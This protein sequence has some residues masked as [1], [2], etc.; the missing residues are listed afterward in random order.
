MASIVKIKRSNVAGNTPTTSNIVEGELALNT[1]DHKLYSRGGGTVFEVG[2]NVSSFS[3]DGVEVVDPSRNIYGNEY[4]IGTSDNHGR[5]QVTNSTT[6]HYGFDP[7]HQYH[8]VLSNEQGSTN[9]AMY[10]ADT[11]DTAADLWGVSLKSDGGTGETTGNESW[12]NK[13]NLTGQG[14]LEISGSFFPDEQI[15]LGNNKGII[16]ESI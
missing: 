1:A 10:L 2:A 8:I 3:I 7:E 14:N 11:G 4:R 13:I 16:L 5:I 9:Q 12:V 15:K 6:S